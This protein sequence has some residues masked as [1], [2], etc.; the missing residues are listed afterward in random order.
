MTPAEKHTQLM[1][2]MGSKS[3]EWDPMPPTQYEAFLDAAESEDNRVWAA[4][5]KRTIGRGDDQTRSPFAREKHGRITRGR[6][7]ATELDMHDSQVSEAL[8]RLEKRGK[9]RRTK[10]GKIWLC[11]NVPPP[12]LEILKGEEKEKEFQRTVK[13]NSD[14][15]EYLRRLQELDE[16]KF[17]ATVTRLVAAQEWGD[18][19]KADAIAWARER[20]AEARQQ[21][22]TES[23]YTKTEV[24]G[25]KR[26][27]P[28][29]DPDRFKVGVSFP[30]FT[31]QNYPVPEASFCEFTVQPGFVAVNRNAKK[32][33]QTP[34]P[35]GPELQSSESQLAYQGEVNAKPKTSE[36]ELKRE[37]AR[38]EIKTEITTRLHR[39]KLTVLGAAKIDAGTLN[40]LANEL[41]RLD[42]AG[43]I[44]EVL[45]V[46][47]ERA[48]EIRGGKRAAG[49]WGYLVNTVRGEVEQ[50]LPADLKTQ[51]IAAAA[52]RG[53]R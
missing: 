15:Q 48:R 49:G 21:V 13:L 38:T 46:L 29:T 9:I 39:A 40:T 43:A 1:K 25:A 23:G 2:E 5:L 45:E 36:A 30:Q 53:M 52:G 18:R 12:D 24:R 41:L 16:N 44:R 4:I 22:F 3:G 14:E 28:A 34:H 17:R 51:I 31:V 33:V 20:E 6:D 26:K 7:I 27:R 50:R 35:Y 11:A 10:D 47:E 8:G 32:R 19:V 42:T 37:A